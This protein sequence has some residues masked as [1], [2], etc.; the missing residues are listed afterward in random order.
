VI[1]NQI[2]KFLLIFQIW[3]MITI[4]YYGYYLVLNKSIP[5]VNFSFSET[6]TDV[7]DKTYDDDFE[8]NTSAT[9]EVSGI[10]D[11]DDLLHTSEIGTEKV[12]SCSA[13][14]R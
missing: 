11:I 7:G 5:L 2:F 4:W 13:E 3:L 14:S 9:E 6:S 8:R 10:S 12:S 1:T